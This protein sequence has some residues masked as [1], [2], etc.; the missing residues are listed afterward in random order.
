MPE[1]R[2]QLVKRAKKKTAEPIEISLCFLAI[3]LAGMALKKSDP[4]EYLLEDKNYNLTEKRIDS[5]N[6][7]I[8]GNE[9]EILIEDTVKNARRN[10]RIFYLCS[11]HDDCASDHKDYQGKIYVDEKAQPTPEEWEYIKQNMIQSFQWVTFRPVWMTTRPHCRHYFKALKS[12]DVLSHSVAQLTRNHRMHHKGGKYE[13]QTVRYKTGEETLK[14]YE[15]RLRYHQ[16]L[17]S[18]YKTETLRKLIQKDKLLIQKWRTYLQR[19]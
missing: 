16:Y 15:E 5:L 6:R 10:G 8:A 7:K 1:I 3:G 19:L 12:E 13:M 11:S 2:K 4:I 9:K 18:Q 17:Y 14:A